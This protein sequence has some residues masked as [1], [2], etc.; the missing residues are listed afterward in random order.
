MTRSAPRDDR[1]RCLRIAR[2]RRLSPARDRETAGPLPRPSAAAARSRSR[3]RRLPRAPLIVV[4]G[5]ETLRLR[6]VL[7]RTRC[8]ARVVTNPRWHEGMATSLRA[9]LA[10]VPRS[11][12]AALVLLVDQPHVG[13]EAV[14][15]LLDAWRLRPS[16]PAAARYERPRGSSRGATAALL[17]CIESATRRS[18]RAGAASR[19][20]GIDAGRHPGGRARHRHAG[21]RARARRR[22]GSTHPATARSS[23]EMTIT[24]SV[25]APSRRWS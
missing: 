21:R 16:L 10:A 24:H 25:F 3:P 15:R 20:G 2:G 19:R 22:K 13:A 8:G 18:R 12:R 7:R 17:A 5:A 23:I 4:V 14:G 9:G 6:L 1:R 11:A